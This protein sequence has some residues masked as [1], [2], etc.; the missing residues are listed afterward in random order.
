MT[1][2]SYGPIG[3]LTV[4]THL[5]PSTGIPAVRQTDSLSLPAIYALIHLSRALAGKGQQWAKGSMLSAHTHSIW[6][7]LPAWGPCPPP[8]FSEL[9]QSLTVSVL[10]KFARSLSS[11]ISSLYVRVSWG[12]LSLRSSTQY[13]G[14]S[15]SSLSAALSFCPLANGWR[16]GASYGSAPS[17]AALASFINRHCPCWHR[18]VLSPGRRVPPADHQHLQPSASIHLLSFTLICQCRCSCLLVIITPAE[19][20]EEIAAARLFMGRQEESRLQKADS[21][22]HSPSSDR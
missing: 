15:C 3:Y 13:I 6:P 22:S 8:L 1:G 16:R 20:G 5:A 9:S 17:T 2:S 18:R 12:C 19:K 21:H 11:L 10:I 4:S 7:A 14:Q